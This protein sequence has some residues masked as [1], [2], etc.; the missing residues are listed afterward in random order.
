MHAT[1]INREV[2]AGHEA[3]LAAFLDNPLKQH[4]VDVTRA[5]PAISVIA[6]DATVVTALYIGAGAAGNPALEH[7]RNAAI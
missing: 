3:S 7:L 4:P 6:Q 5:K 1:A 2:L